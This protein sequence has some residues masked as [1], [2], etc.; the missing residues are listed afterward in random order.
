MVWRKSFAVGLTF[1]QYAATAVG[2]TFLLSS[3]FSVCPY[4]QVTETYKGETAAV[5][6]FGKYRHIVT[7]PTPLEWEVTACEQLLII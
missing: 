2:L 5:I 6:L 4:Y 7:E 1:L 3:F